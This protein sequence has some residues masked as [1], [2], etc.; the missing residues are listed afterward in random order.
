M[1]VVRDKK[2]KIEHDH[3]HEDGTAASERDDKGSN[4]NISEEAEE[5][6]ILSGSGRITSSGIAE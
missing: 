1:Y 2:R 5:I 3:P 6:K 4:P